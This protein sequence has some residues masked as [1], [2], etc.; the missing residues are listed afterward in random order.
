MELYLVGTSYANNIRYYKLLSYP[1]YKVRQF[2]EADLQFLG[3]EMVNARL[4]PEGSLQG[5]TGSL[6]RLNDPNAITVI[7]QVDAENY[8]IYTR[9][10]IWVRSIRVIEVL[11][12]NGCLLNA[13]IDNNSL[14]GINWNIPQEGVFLKDHTEHYAQD[15]IARE[16]KTVKSEAIIKPKINTQEVTLLSDLPVIKT[17]SN[18]PLEQYVSNASSRLPIQKDI[19]SFVDANLS[20]SDCWFFRYIEQFARQDG[21]I[22]QGSYDFINKYLQ[23]ILSIM[24][25]TPAYNQE[26]YLI[27]KLF[28]AR[29]QYSTGFPEDKYLDIISSILGLS[30]AELQEF[31]DCCRYYTASQAYHILSK[32]STKVKDFSLLAGFNTAFTQRFIIN[33][34]RAQS[35]ISR[36]TGTSGIVDNSLSFLELGTL[37]VTSI[38]NPNTGSSDAYLICNKTSVEDYC[39]LVAPMRTWFDNTINQDRFMT[40]LHKCPRK[41]NISLD[42]KFI[43][44]SITE[45]DKKLIKK[46]LD[47]DIARSDRQIIRQSELSSKLKITEAEAKKLIAFADS[48]SAWLIYKNLTDSVFV[49]QAIAGNLLTQGTVNTLM[50]SIKP[51]AD[52]YPKARVINLYGG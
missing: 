6:T 10:K 46:L 16:V 24:G 18:I 52:K 39:N 11:A 5:L 25:I 44:V 43:C 8:K 27:D 41:L 49:Q 9:G 33:N 45:Y 2:S 47:I 21:T 3:V 34:K 40:K 19:Y 4:T 36:Y 20:K 28:V 29:Q 1:S 32:H 50:Q 15:A 37:P 22:N 23:N 30:K 51:L 35:N 13:I 14:R 38:L 7:R 26:Q 17:S 48:Q 12:N 31:C 42:N